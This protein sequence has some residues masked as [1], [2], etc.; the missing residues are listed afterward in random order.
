LKI[1][2]N[3]Q[4]LDMRDKAIPRLYAAGRTTGGVLGAVFPASGVNLLDALCFGRI[5]GRNAALS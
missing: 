2:A 1:N 3:A 5:A 4:V